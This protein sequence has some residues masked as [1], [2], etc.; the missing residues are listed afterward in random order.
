MRPKRCALCGNLL[1]FA[2]ADTPGLNNC[3]N[4]TKYAHVQAELAGHDYVELSCGCSAHVDDAIG[5]TSTLYLTTVLGLAGMPVPDDPGFQVWEAYE[6]L[7]MSFDDAF[8]DGVEPGMLTCDGASPPSLDPE[9]YLDEVLRI[10]GV[11]RTSLLDAAREFD[12]RQALV[13]GEIVS[14]YETCGCSTY[15]GPGAHDGI[16]EMVECWFDDLESAIQEEMGD[17]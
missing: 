17:G 7:D 14:H 8:R 11:T 2:Y 13:V 12:A 1:G 4:C 16:M 9:T 15:P 10:D 3:E 6:Y 5:A